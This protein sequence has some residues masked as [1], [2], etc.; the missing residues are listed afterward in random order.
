MSAP[1][2]KVQEGGGCWFHAPLNGWLLS[3][4][5]REVI[6]AMLAQYKSKHSIN[7]SANLPHGAICP[8]RGHLPLNYF[9]RY[10]NLMLSNNR[11]K[12]PANFISNLI[13]KNT[14]L[15]PLPGVSA[16]I[17]LKD[18]FDGYNINFITRSELIHN[19]VNSINTLTHEKLNKVTGPVNKLKRWLNLSPNNKLKEINMIKA[20][21]R[22]KYTE[23][24]D[25]RD[26]HRF[27]RILFGANYSESENK[28][29]E[30]TVVFATPWPGGRLRRSIV[31]NKIRYTL[32]HCCVLL[33][34]ADPKK[35]G[36]YVS[37]FIDSKMQGGG[38]GMY[39]SEFPHVYSLDWVTSAKD[40]QNFALQ[41]GLLLNKRFSL[42]I[43]IRDGA[44]NFA[45]EINSLGARR[46]DVAKYSRIR[47]ILDYSR[48]LPDYLIAMNEFRKLPPN[49]NSR[50]YIEAR[51]VVTRVTANK[52]SKYHQLI[53]QISSNRN[54]LAKHRNAL[55]KPPLSLIPEFSSVLSRVNTLIRKINERNAANAAARTLVAARAAAKRKR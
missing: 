27:H 5:G 9:W 38:M 3:E 44:A 45:S 17:N 26:I 10:V 35:V 46:N 19:G 16:N 2:L 40:M 13:I 53:S 23:L 21:I 8:Q 31:R 33:E 50:N 7:T 1:L 11:T 30:N 18:L 4:R 54:E 36:H 52:V 24:G 14:G 29:T 12:N 6:S 43:Y 41:V 20:K 28:V 47:A 51:A 15:R 34:S 55:L 37:G 39:D 49:N 25:Y 22:S 48:E 42:M 32:S